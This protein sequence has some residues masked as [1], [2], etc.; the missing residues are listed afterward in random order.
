MKYDQ[1][2]VWGWTRCAV[3]KLLYSRHE[4]KLKKGG[5]C[6][7]HYHEHRANRFTVIEGEVLIVWVIGWE[8]FSKQ[9]TSGLSVVVPSLVAHQFQAVD[10]SL[11][12]EAYWGDRGSA[13]VLE[14]D[15]HRFTTG[16]L[17][18]DDL[19]ASKCGILL[20]SGEYHDVWID[21]RAD[22]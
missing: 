20:E 14:D 19:D 1:E 11:M 18:I 16:G 12:E 21:P 22:I 10:K 2:K 4:L 9:L 13:C 3:S 17:L 8:L 5:F 7:F 6:S 15:I